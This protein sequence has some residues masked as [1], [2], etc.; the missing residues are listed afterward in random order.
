MN[1][2]R[3]KS[4][5]VFLV[6]S[7][8]GFGPVSLTCLIGMYIVIRRPP[9]FHEVVRNLYHDNSTGPELYP[10][11]QRQIDLAPSAIRV[12]CF[13]S[14]V[15][16]LVLDIA[17][18]PVAGSIGLYIVIMRPHWFKALVENIYDGVGA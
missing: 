5:L 1:Y 9:W 16:L 15:F 2:T 7:I 6:F 8:I 14:L 18:V 13:L 11:R 10:P 17:P 12:K 3:I 4:F